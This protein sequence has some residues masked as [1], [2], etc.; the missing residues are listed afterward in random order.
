M[1]KRPDEMDFEEYMAKFI[2]QEPKEW[3]CTVC[4]T[5]FLRDRLSGSFCP[6]VHC[7]T[8]PYCGVWNMDEG[9]WL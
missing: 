4:G 1:S 6:C 5:V 3:K 7:S 2:R 9:D 8:C